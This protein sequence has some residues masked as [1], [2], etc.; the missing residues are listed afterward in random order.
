[1]R[2]VRR[3]A[4]VWRM[5]LG[6]WKHRQRGSSSHTIKKLSAWVEQSH[7]AP[8]KRLR[9]RSTSRR[10]LSIRSRMH[11]KRI[12]NNRRFSRKSIS[13]SHLSNSF[14]AVTSSSLSHQYDMTKEP[15]ELKQTAT[16]TAQKPPLSRA[17]TVR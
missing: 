13:N 9:F 7:I 10:K 15:L 4:A 14:R 16:A 2:I 12:L 17:Q 5:S 11:I 1:M 3:T 8:V 6:K